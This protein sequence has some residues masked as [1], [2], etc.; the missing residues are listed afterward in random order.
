MRIKSD[1]FLKLDLKHSDPVNVD[2]A[3]LVSVPF[4]SCLASLR[5]MAH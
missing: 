4:N 2:A 5:W 3:I 1:E